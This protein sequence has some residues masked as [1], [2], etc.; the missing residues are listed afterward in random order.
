[1]AERI[2]DRDRLSAVGRFATLDPDVGWPSAEHDYPEDAIMCALDTARERAQESAEA[3]E[4]RAVEL[5]ARHER[6]QAN[7]R[8]SHR[9]LAAVLQATGKQSVGDIPGVRDELLRV[10]VLGERVESLEAALRAIVTNLD[11]ENEDGNIFPDAALTRA[12]SV[13]DGHSPGSD[14]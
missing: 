13:L 11:G 2:N 1:M 7:A 10:A 6:A 8:A 9:S 3:A 12:R 14:G 5:E 4:A